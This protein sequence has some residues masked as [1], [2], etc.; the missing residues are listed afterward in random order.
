[1]ARLRVTARPRQNQADDDGESIADIVHSPEELDEILNEE[2]GHQE[3]DEDENGDEDDESIADGQQARMRHERDELADRMMRNP[4]GDGS[5]KFYTNQNTLYLLHC[6]KHDR[7]MLSDDAIDAFAAVGH[8]E[9][10]LSPHAK[11]QQD[12]ERRRIA[13]NLL[14]GDE[15]PV[16]LELITGKRFLSYLL[17]LRNAK[18]NTRLSA[19]SYQSKRS[20]LF[21]LFRSFRVP[22]P[23][24]LKEDLKS[25]M[26]GLKRTVAREKQ[27]GDGRIEVGKEPMS[28][29]L[30]KFLATNFL[31]MSGSDG[32]FGWCFLVLSWNLAC[33]SSNTCTLQL[34]HFRWI[35]DCF[36][37]F[38]AHQKND[39]GGTK[40]H[41]RHIYPNPLEPVICPLLALTMYLLLFGHILSENG[42]LFPGNDQY[43]RFSKLL[44]RTID[45]HRDTII[46]MGH[47]PEFIG[48]HS[49]RKGAATYASSGSTSGP[50][51]AAVN[52]RVGWTLGNT[53]DLYIW[54]EAAGDQYC[55]RVL[56]GLPLSSHKFAI[57]GPRFFLN[58][59]VTQN[60]VSYAVKTCFVKGPANFEAILMHGLATCL[61]HY[62]F[63]CGALSNNHRVLSCA[64]FKNNFN[65]LRGNIKAGL[66]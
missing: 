1:M 19:S 61:F 21:H 14:S 8:G 4:V 29:A 45:L 57:I 9:E 58:E 11:K 34:K 54:Y 17:S 66:P 51:G 22:Q 35:E 37:I 64:L 40:K 20:G 32:F 6:L 33:R 5:T 3:E 10:E 65:V 41:P 13:R 38:F 47:D 2:D 48:V 46:S 23:P 55:G 50:S 12:K 36:A 59:S 49:I 43:I 16:K 27:R 52:L 25:A 18:N 56:S 26:K 39:Q 31:E 28:F 42:S 15:C 7:E 62:D 60:I 63:L 53:Q 24:T 44:K 30:Y